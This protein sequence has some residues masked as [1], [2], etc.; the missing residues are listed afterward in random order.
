MIYSI[1]KLAFGTGPTRI[2]SEAEMDANLTESDTS[3][4]LSQDQ[5]MDSGE[6]DPALH[7]VMVPPSAHAGSH[8][9]APTSGGLP[10]MELLR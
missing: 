7:S 10:Y 1:G 2:A 4:A 8:V 9:G 3:E 6:A 5:D